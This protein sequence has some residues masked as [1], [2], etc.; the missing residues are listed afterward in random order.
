ML[1]MRSVMHVTCYPRKFKAIAFNGLCRESA[2]VK[3]A[4]CNYFE[5]ISH[6]RGIRRLVLILENAFTCEYQLAREQFLGK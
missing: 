5:H 2:K 1:W 6:I 4:L 3:Y